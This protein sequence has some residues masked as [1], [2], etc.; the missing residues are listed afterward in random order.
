MLTITVK[1]RHTDDWA[2]SS[3]HDHFKESDTILKADFAILAEYIYKGRIKVSAVKTEVSFFHLNNKMA[4][5][6]LEIPFEDHQLRHKKLQKYLGVILD[7]SFSFKKHFSQSAAKINSRNNI[8]HKLCG[9]TCGSSIPNLRFSVLCWVLI[10]YGSI[11]SIQAERHPAEQYSA[12]HIWDKKKS[13]LLQI[14]P[15]LYWVTFVHLSPEKKVLI[16]EYQK[17]IKKPQLFIHDTL[18]LLN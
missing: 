15:F 2:T 13:N 16:K 18:T 9:T 6:K 14:I 12:Y 10:P 17:I 11:V 7:R 3:K 1:N 4:N 5:R 8:I